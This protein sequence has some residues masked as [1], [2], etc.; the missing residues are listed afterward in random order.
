MET[1]WGLLLPFNYLF[2]VHEQRSPESSYKPL[3]SDHTQQQ[4]KLV[5]LGDLWIPIQTL[6]LWQYAT[7]IFTRLLL[8]RCLLKHTKRQV[9]QFFRSAFFPNVYHRSLRIISY[10]TP[11]A[12]EQVFTLVSLGDLCNNVFLFIYYRII[13]LQF[14]RMDYP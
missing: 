7:T 1:S 9:K 10:Q 11:M 4:C 2:F 14:S 5:S 6:M 3:E 13:I 12:K 8:I